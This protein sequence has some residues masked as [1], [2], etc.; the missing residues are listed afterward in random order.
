[1][2]ENIPGMATVP[3]SEFKK[4]DIRVARVLSVEN[5]PNADK[6]YVL[7]VDSGAGERQIVAG[8]RP[9]YKAE[10]LAGRAIVMVVNLE[11]AV[12]RGVQ[13]QGMLLAATDAGR[14]MLLRPDAEAAPGARIS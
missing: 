7:K 4:L 9:Y 8:L 13:S 11:P 10:E 12:L 5:H 1:M 6:L 2:E 14:V 3:F